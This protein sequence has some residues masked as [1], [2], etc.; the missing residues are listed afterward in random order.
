[1]EEMECPNID[2]QPLMNI[3]V[4]VKQKYVKPFKVKKIGDKRKSKTEVCKA[5]QSKKIGG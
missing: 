5:I 4:K 3:K 1:M 2:S